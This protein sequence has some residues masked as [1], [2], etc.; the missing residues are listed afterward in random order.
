MGAAA[1]APEQRQRRL[2]PWQQAGPG[3]EL[4]TFCQALN[5]RLHLQGAVR[6][7]MVLLHCQLR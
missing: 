3:L 1:G 5:A 7:V 4:P 6:W 2:R